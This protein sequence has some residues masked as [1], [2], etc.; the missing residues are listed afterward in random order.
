MKFALEVGNETE[1]VKLEYF[2]NQLFG[3][4][5]IKLNDQEV[6]KNNRIFS[7]P[8]REHHDFQLGERQPFSVRIEKRDGF[9]RPDRLDAYRRSAGGKGRNV[10]F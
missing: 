6:K 10:C 7:G 4:M 8:W 2:S 9:S 1:T 5:I 3:S